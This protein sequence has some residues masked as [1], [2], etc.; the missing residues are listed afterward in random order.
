MCVAREDSM[1]FLRWVL[2]NSGNSILFFLVFL[3]S[4][5]VRLRGRFSCRSKAV[6]DWEMPL[7]AWVESVCSVG[8]IVGL[9]RGEKFCGRVV[10]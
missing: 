5:I 4:S 8:L 6:V 2:I 10:A 1:G 3:G 9:L 7:L